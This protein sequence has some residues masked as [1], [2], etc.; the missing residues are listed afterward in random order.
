MVLF[1]M[2]ISIG[3]AQADYTFQTYQ[4][5]YPTQAMSYSTVQPY[6]QQYNQG[7]YQNP[8]QTQCQGH[9]LNPYQ[10]RR[11][12]YRYGNNLPYPYAQ[13]NSTVTGTDTTGSTGQIV[14]NIG[15]SVIYSMM[16]GY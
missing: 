15:Q 12:Y 9:Y 8:Y 13:T 14:R 4:P 10:Y 1:L 16:R 3:S 6:T 5:L 11:P 2:A 7:Y